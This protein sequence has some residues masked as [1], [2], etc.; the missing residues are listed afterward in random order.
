MKACLF[1]CHSGLQIFCLI[2]FIENQSIIQLALTPVH[3]FESTRLLQFRENYSLGSQFSQLFSIKRRNF[4]KFSISSWWNFRLVWLFWPWP[5]VL[6]HT[7]L[8]WH[9]G[10]AKP[11]KSLIRRRSWCFR[12]QLWKTLWTL[13][14]LIPTPSSAGRLSPVEIQT[15]LTWQSVENPTTLLSKW[16]LSVTSA[17]TNF[18]FNLYRRTYWIP[19]GMSSKP[20]PCNLPGN[21]DELAYDITQ[22]VVQSGMN[23]LFWY[24]FVS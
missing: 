17:Y 15:Q 20:T 3:I 22:T 2:I 7:S 23:Y 18:L 9:F 11:W 24:I 5:A 1:S 6:Q 14:R 19:Y 12:A 16:R 8:R 10:L 21:S 13:L 4:L